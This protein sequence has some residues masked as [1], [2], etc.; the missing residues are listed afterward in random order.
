MGASGLDIE[1]SSGPVL[2]RRDGS[3]YYQNLASC[4]ISCITMEL[5][6]GNELGWICK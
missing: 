5:R 2:S 3:A 1:A 6:V 4:I